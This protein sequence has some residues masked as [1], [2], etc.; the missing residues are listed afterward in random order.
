MLAKLLGGAV[1]KSVGAMGHRP[2][3]GDGAWRVVLGVD[4][5]N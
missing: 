2:I 4:G 3:S 5:G 1:T